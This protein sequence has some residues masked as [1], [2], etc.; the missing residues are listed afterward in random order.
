MTKQQLESYQSN[1]AEIAELQYKLKHINE[2]GAMIDHSTILDY[3]KGYPIP[4]A[5]IGVNP[6]RYQKK[7]KKYK[8]KIDALTKE[9]EKIEDFIEEI[10]D[11]LTRRILY[12]HYV[13]GLSQKDI[14]QIIHIDRSCVSRKIIN[15][16]LKNG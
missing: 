8:Q 11:I 5:V 4:R 1:I 3:R 10:P 12:M 16:F 14:G 2:G 6:D 9:C 15:Y 7:E 13:E